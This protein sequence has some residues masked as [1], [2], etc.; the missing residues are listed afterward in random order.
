MMEEGSKKEEKEGVQ[1]K[2]VDVTK[3]TLLTKLSKVHSSPVLRPSLGQT[4]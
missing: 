3:L 2:G 1:E 4:P